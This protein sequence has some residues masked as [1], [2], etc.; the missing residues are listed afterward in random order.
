M[1]D[2]PITDNT[3]AENVTVTEYLDPEDWQIAF[4]LYEGNRKL[5]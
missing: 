5:L 2:N 1:P 3:D 4:E